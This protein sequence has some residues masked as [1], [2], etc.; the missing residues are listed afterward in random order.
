M[1]LYGYKQ[2]YIEGRSNA[3]KQ[4]ILELGRVRESQN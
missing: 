2:G 1:Y 4:I 3:F